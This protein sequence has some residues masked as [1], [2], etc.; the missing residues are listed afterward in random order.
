M[1]PL[2]FHYISV[3]FST[4]EVLVRKT[5][6]HMLV[7]DVYLF[8]EFGDLCTISEHTELHPQNFSTQNPIYFDLSPFLSNQL[9]QLIKQH[10]G[11]LQYIIIKVD[12]SDSQGWLPQAGWKWLGKS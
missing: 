2:Q 3:A 7:S 4:T 12:P 10:M 11:T 9:N 5:F 8:T 1:P 6:T